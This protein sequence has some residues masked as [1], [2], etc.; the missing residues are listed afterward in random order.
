MHNH[1]R[2]VVCLGLMLV[3][4]G[5][6]M[7]S[8]CRGDAICRVKGDSKAAPED[9]SNW[10]KAYADL[11]SALAN[12]ACNEIWVAVGTYK[13]SSGEGRGVTYSLRS[14]VALYGGFAGNEAQ[15]DKRDWK[16]NITI[17]SGDL[18]GNDNA[19]IT[20]DEAT[21][22]DNAYHVLYADSGVDASAIL[23][24]FTVTG[25]NA[26]GS[27]NNENV[28]GGMNCEGSPTLRNISFSRN[29]AA[30][31]GG[32]MDNAGSPALTE[33][34]FSGNVG[35]TGGGF[36][37]G[38]TRKPTLR[39][40]SFIGN[41]ALYFGGG[42]HN[43]GHMDLANVT[44][45]GNTAAFSG[46]GLF[47]NGPATLTNATFAG[48]TADTGGALYNDHD[49]IVS[50]SHVTLGSNSA[51]T[52]TGG[53]YTFEASAALYNSLLSGNTGGNCGGTVSA[54]TDSL[55]D[56]ASCG[57]ATVNATGIGL[58]PLAQNGGTTQTMALGVGS[59]AV[60]IADAGRCTATDQRG[61]ARPRGA[62]CDVGAYEK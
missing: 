47:N 19:T 8:P 30:E 26:N 56:D 2:Y 52:S 57:S 44:F 34:T 5:A 17:L 25:G 50:L 20:A 36:A 11:Q 58:L 40:V 4:L 43:S 35:K 6:G 33:V 38:G 55:S 15:R 10:D 59:A 29:A 18:N 32:G 51:T 62:R 1:Q 24:G 42:L 13:P 31:S 22:T 61:V 14:G 27:G 37:N 39:N 16:A 41:A 49:G 54:G 7:P 60:D 48:N 46:G 3:T 28:G 21:R 53:I 23:D 9:G 12:T 45:A